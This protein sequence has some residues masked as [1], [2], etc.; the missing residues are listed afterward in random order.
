MLLIGEHF[1]YI[2]Q[3]FNALENKYRM[4]MFVYLLSD[5]VYL[6]EMLEGCRRI[7]KGIHPII[8]GIAEVGQEIKVL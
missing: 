6:F 7:S 8:D 1:T 5:F 3:I 4:H 2:L